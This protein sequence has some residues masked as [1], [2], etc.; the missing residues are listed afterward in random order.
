MSTQ[1]IITVFS[2]KGQKKAKIET[3][4][5]TWGELS[6]L[7]K[8][9]GYD[10]DNL[11]ATE[12]INK[13]DLVNTQAVLPEGDFTIFLRP[14]K[15]KSGAE[16]GMGLSYKEIKA[17]IKEDF[18]KYPEEA[19]AHYN[20]GDNYTRKGTET[21]RG[22]VNS[23]VAPTGT[24][25]AEPKPAKKEKVKAEEVV[26]TITLTNADHAESIKTDLLAII[27]NASSDDV[28][29]RA[30]EILED[31]LPGLETAI[32]EDTNA[33]VTTVEAVN[34]NIADVVKSVGDSKESAEE[35]GRRIA[36][37]KAEQEEAE[38]IAQEKAEKESAK[39]AEREE[40]E[41]LAKEAEELGLS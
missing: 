4:V 39:E 36:R 31:L 20:E 3:N 27:G 33:S 25:K 15:T 35:E 6:P 22:L 14:K 8:N 23:F 5:T 2:T 19:V 40:N 32:A 16:R 7:V 12:N 28:K 21:L 17:V 26:E 13:S 9:E 1:R 30:T 38:K 37:E 34:T 24:A 29:E 10:L 18:E 41:R 11:H